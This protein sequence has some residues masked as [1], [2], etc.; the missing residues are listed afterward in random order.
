MTLHLIKLAVGID[1]LAHLRA[2]Q[3]ARLAAVGRLHHRT[4]NTPRRAGELLD[5]GSMYWVIRGVVRVRQRLIGIDSAAE[6][7][8]DGAPGPACSLLLDPS[9]IATVPRAHRPFQGW[10]YL[11]ADDAPADL[12]ESVAGDEEREPLPAAMVAE[13]AKLG[14]L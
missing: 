5:G 11:R 3:A 4:R 6:P 10:R 8:A 2:I 14:L 12:P 9:F 13:L 7:G 1:S